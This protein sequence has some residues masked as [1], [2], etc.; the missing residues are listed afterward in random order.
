VAA[1]AKLVCMWFVSISGPRAAYIAISFRSVSLRAFVPILEH[2]YISSFVL[3]RR[4]SPIRNST[5]V[6]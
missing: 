3:V 2:S 6:Q 5:M 1:P 4:R